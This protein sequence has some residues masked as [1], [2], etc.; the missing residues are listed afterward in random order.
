MRIVIFV[1][2]PI[3]IVDKDVIFYNFFSATVPS[4]TFMIQLLLIKESFTLAT[5]YCKN[6]FLFFFLF[7]V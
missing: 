3:D 6:H 2:S 1:G 7:L 5:Y 4:I